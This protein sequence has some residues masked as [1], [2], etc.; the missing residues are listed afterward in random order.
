MSILVQKD[1]ARM[2]TSNSTNSKNEILQLERV[3][4]KGL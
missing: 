1:T 2:V 4:A 3:F